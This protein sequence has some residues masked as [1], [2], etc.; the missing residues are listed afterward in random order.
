FGESLE[1]ENEK[2]KENETDKTGTRSPP[3]TSALAGHGVLHRRRE[4]R[5]GLY[6]PRQGRAVRGQAKALADGEVRSSSASQ[7]GGNQSGAAVGR[8]CSRRG[9]ARGADVARA[10][11]RTCPCS[12]GML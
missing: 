1:N 12:S 10:D 5:T 11:A 8:N 9:I 2:E 4:I 7:L 3:Q 6:G